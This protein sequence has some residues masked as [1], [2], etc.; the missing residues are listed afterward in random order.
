MKRGTAAA[1][2]AANPILSDGEIGF[3]TDTSKIKIGNGTSTWTAL[4]YFPADW[5]SITSK[6]AVIAS[7]ATQLEARTA[8]GLSNVDNTADENKIVASASK[9]TTARNINGVA[10][11]GTQNITVPSGIQRSIGSSNVSLTL[12]AATDTDYVYFLGGTPGTPAT[13]GDPHWSSVTSYLN[14]NSTTTTDSAL[15]PQTWTPTGSLT[16]NTTTKKFGNSSLYI[17]T[18]GQYL[19]APSSNRFNMGGRNPFTA[20]LW[21]NPNDVSGIKPYLSFRENNVVCPI[22][23]AQTGSNLSI[24]IGNAALNAWEVQNFVSSTTYFIAGSWTHIAVVGTGTELWFYINGVPVFGWPQPNWSPTSYPLIIGG[25]PWWAWSTGYIDEFRFTRGVARYSNAFN[26]ATSEFLTTTPTAAVSPIYANPTLPTA[27]N[28]KNVYTLRNV[29]TL[30]LTVSTTLSQ[31]IED[32]PSYQIDPG[33]TINF[34]SD[35]SNWRII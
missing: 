23:V 6:P 15:N 35:G 5:T 4:N 30:P 7:G 11:D 18:A 31:T 32:Q 29:F 1:W 34:I 25:D 24:H 17:S 16:I 14:F 22:I 13:A 2:A 33:E 27:I 28:N 3:E 9:L 12:P 8:I 10:F 26:L 19:Y 20:E 21:V